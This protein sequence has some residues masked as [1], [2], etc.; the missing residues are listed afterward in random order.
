MDSKNLQISGFLN[1]FRGIELGSNG[2]LF[3][4]VFIWFCSNLLFAD[5]N[6]NNSSG[7]LFIIVV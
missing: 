7:L 4:F 5:N 2:I 3:S 1:N 6:H